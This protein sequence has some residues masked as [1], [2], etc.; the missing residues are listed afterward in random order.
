MFHRILFSL[1]VLSLSISSAQA[2]STNTL[3][4]PRLASADNF[5][6]VA[7]NT[8]AYTTSNNGVMRGGVFYRSNQLTVSPK[9]LA[10]LDTL[11]IS[12][13]F[14]LRTPEEIASAPDL[15][16]DGASYTTFDV[17]GQAFTNINFTSADQS[18]A[19]MEAGEREFVTDPNVRS[20]FGNLMR[21]LAS[22]E[23][24]AVFHCTA[25]KDRT[26]WTAAVLQSLAG[27]DEETIMAD[28]LSTN[29]YTAE[30]VAAT[31]D[32]LNAISPDMAAAYEPLL[33]VQASFLQAGLDQ[34]EA[35]YG[36]MDNYL[37]EGLGLDQETIYVLRG[38]MVRYATLPGQQYFSGNDA[39]GAS[40]LNALQDTSLA[41]TYSAYN[42]Y[43]QS[44]IDA[45]SLGGLESQVGGQVHADASAYL[46]RQASLIEDALSPYAAGV[47]LK[48]GESSLWMTGLA[49]YLGTDGSRSTAS[50]NE[51]TKG[52]VVGGVHRFNERTSANVA[53]GYNKG[54]IGSAGGDVNTDSTFISAG[55]RY[56][57][58]SL[59]SGAYLSVQVNAGYIDYSSK[60]DLT[61]GLGT[62]KGDTHGSFYG[63]KGSLGYRMTRGSL[64][65]EP[66]IGLRTSYVQLD[67][68]KEKGSELALDVD[69]TNRSL[70]S[71]VAGVKLGFESRL[72][73][74]WRVTPGLQLGYEHMLND[75]KVKSSASVLG[76]GIDQD[77]AFDSDNMIKAGLNISA[78]HQ[79]LTL[80]ADFNVLSG[81]ESSG[82]SGQINASIAF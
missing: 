56:A 31:L 29:A 42:F 14:D 79:A 74:D 69:S 18:I 5:R 34:V 54:S 9:D 3:D 47:N 37:K 11:N 50:S 26:G 49:G 82:L 8:T 39:A 24:A 71:V 27:V 70:N 19:M 81:D 57:F 62:A 20:E 23:D 53:F 76:L 38:K 22:S 46:L 73:A 12:N 64:L 68:F 66:E 58:D 30:R 45:G 16:P 6:D 35:T 17:T 25:G 43:L 4:T 15:L 28:Y 33:G 10:T 80:G 63:A 36:S 1:S 44:A 72:V 13:V 67:G 21:A 55:S 40:L 32:Q 7:G 78:S 59:E 51:H 48:A 65:I 52:A 77:S 60:R 41:G 75:P 2:A 61:G